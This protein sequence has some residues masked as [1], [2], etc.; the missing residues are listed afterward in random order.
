MNPRPTHPGFW[1]TRRDDV[2][3]VLARFVWDGGAARPLPQR[4]HRHAPLARLG[5]LEKVNLRAN[6][7]SDI[8]P[9]SAVPARC[10]VD[11]LENPIDD[12]T[13]LLTRGRKPTR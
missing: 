7:I 12:I 3:G 8:R 6:R 1:D 5:K 11:L 4:P 9:I 2:A 13:P 10:E